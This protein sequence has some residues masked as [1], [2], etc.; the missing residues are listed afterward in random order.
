MGV[1]ELRKEKHNFTRGEFWL[2]NYAA[3]TLN[4]VDRKKHV[5][6]SY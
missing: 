6:E 4:C 5:L 2:S 3:R 1:F